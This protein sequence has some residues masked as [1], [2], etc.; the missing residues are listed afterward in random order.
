MR[1]TKKFMSLL[2][3]ITMITAMMPAMAFAAQS[4]PVEITSVEITDLEKPVA[5]G[6]PNYSAAVPEGA[7][8]HLGSANELYEVGYI[9]LTNNYNGI[10]WIYDNTSLSSDES[11]EKGKSYRAEMIL[12][13][14]DG[15]VFAENLSATINGES[16]YISSHTVS[17][18]A[19]SNSMEAIDNGQLADYSK[20]NA[21]IK[22]IPDDLELYTDN[23][24]KVLND[25]RNAVVPDLDVT[26]QAEVDKM[27]ADIEEAIKGLELKTEITSVEITD[28]EKPVAGE[29]PD[30][31]ASVPENAPYHFASHEELQKTLFNNINENYNGIW[32]VGQNGNLTPDKV[33]EKGLFYY[34]Q[35]VLIPNDGYI[36]AKKVSGTVN[37]ESCVS[38]SR[39]KAVF[40]ESSNVE[41]IAHKVADVTLNEYFTKVND[42]TYKYSTRGK[43]VNARPIVKDE[44][45]NVLE[46]NADYKVTYSDN[47]R[48]MPGKYTI[49][50]EG[51]GGYTGE[52]EKILIITPESVDKVKVRQT[53]AKGGYDDAYVTWGKSEGADGYQ[54]YARRPSKTS[55]WSYLG[56][57]EKTSFLE[58]DLYDGYKY[59]FKVIPYKLIDGTRYRTSENYETVSMYTM[60]KVSKPS[61]KK[62]SSSRVR[63]SWNNI[64]GESGYQVMASRTGK[65][66]YFITSGTSVK[67]SV[68]KNKKYTY[69]VRA[70]K[71]VTK[72]GKTYR[73]F[74]PWSDAGTYTLR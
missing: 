66:T 13:P 48:V 33:F 6:K 24:V 29:Y 18:Y 8:Y 16:C 34:A 17:A 54:I 58:K 1:L 25:A 9:D 74:A 12:I 46:E 67:V 3:T 68:A 72:S 63:I 49:K 51:I 53:T 57:T 23:T 38:Y 30:Y 61:V 39:A 64:S 41:A 62:Y 28:L 44:T 22:K 5:G 55:K 43:H 21:A 32:W 4:G 40:V 56:R 37:G 10:W 26:R 45:G 31:Y 2:L 15:Y 47:E 69:K 52:I 60:K 73:V 42:D 70:Y 35:I 19:R 65:T 71:N 20:V 11:F 14:D 27:A 50:V 36:F 7:P 59:E